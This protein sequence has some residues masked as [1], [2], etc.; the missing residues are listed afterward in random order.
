MAISSATRSLPPLTRTPSIGTDA[1]RNVNE[2]EVREQTAA[3]LD[4]LKSDLRADMAIIA[5]SDPKRRYFR[6]DIYPEYKFNRTHGT[7]PSTLPL[8]KTILRNGIDGYKV[9][10]M[11]GLEADDILGII[12]SLPDKP[13]YGER[14]VVTT[15][16][17]LKQIPGKHYNPDKSKQGVTTVTEAQGDYFFYTQIL[18]GDPTDGYPGC[19][20][21]G[22]VKAEKILL[23]AL[24]DNMV[25]PAIVAAYERAGLD[26]YEALR[27]ARVARILRHTDYD[28][29]ARKVILWN[30]TTSLQQ[31]A[32]PSPV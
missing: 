1:G 32:L 18:T 23:T 7:P 30:P 31:A 19:R 17:D 24:K 3:W 21:I 15:D 11:P 28:F 20:G 25:W 9:W 8:V 14:I 4:E 2:N 5:L 6:H 13:E 10:A 26:E 27:Q 22:P 16:K 29:A 12:A